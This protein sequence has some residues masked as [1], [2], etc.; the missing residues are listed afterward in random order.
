MISKTAIVIPDQ[1]FPIHDQSAVNCALKVLEVAK[2]DIFINLGDVG[3]WESVSAWRWRDKKQPPL[4]YQLP[5]VYEEIKA[6]NKG[7]DVIDSS[8]DKAGTKERHFVEG[9]HE[10]WLNRFVEENPYL[11]KDIPLKMHYVLKSVDTSIIGSERCSRLV[12]LISTTGIILQEL[13]TLVIISFVSVVMLCMV[14]IMIFSKALL[15]TLTGLSQ[16]GQ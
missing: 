11:A 12:K 5:F 9:N 16:R 8:L 10:D 3:E 6:V 7:M 15:H 14:T 2:P 4:E 1:H 13:I